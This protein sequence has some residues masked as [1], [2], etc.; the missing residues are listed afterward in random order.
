[1]SCCAP[2]LGAR[3]KQSQEKAE[4]QAL[5]DRARALSDLRSEGGSPFRLKALF[6]VKVGDDVL[7]GDYVLT[8]QSKNR[9]RDELTFPRF[10]QVR[11]ST[12][13]ATWVSRN[14]NHQPLPVLLFLL[15]L[16]PDLPSEIPKDWQ[17]SISE[18]QSSG[19]TLL[20][21]QPTG[22]NATLAE[23]KCVDV[24]LL[25]VDRNYCFDSS[26]GLLTRYAEWGTA[27]E[28]S[29]YS[30]WNGK[31]YPEILHITQRDREIAEARITSLVAASNVS[32]ETFLPPGGAEERPR[33]EHPSRP[34]LANPLGQPI[35]PRFRSNHLTPVW[36]EVG[37]DGRV[38]DAVFLVPLADREEE[39]DLFKLLRRQRFE[40]ANCGKVA[41]PSAIIFWVS[42]R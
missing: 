9:W 21:E 5:F 30:L 8:W 40:P 11:V 33:C 36:I 39:H 28:Y 35:L 38:E 37:A 19:V 20:N 31:R 25:P 17:V 22:Q 13:E 1:V 10:V 27:W 26:S 32:P 29:Y 6:H 18:R 24:Q 14:T 16:H 23:E 41:I 4:A 2:T 12:E 15:G 34:T 42:V 7:A 3:V